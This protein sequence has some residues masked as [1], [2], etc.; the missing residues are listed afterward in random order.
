MVK[1]KKRFACGHQGYG[2]VCHRCQQKEADRIRRK[3]QRQAWEESFRY[4]PIDLRSFPKN[5]VKKTRKIIFQLNKDSNYRRFK[6]KRLRHNRF[7][8]SIPINRNYRLICRDEGSNIVPEA[9]VSH[10]DY[11]VCKP[12]N[13]K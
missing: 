7:M 12:G 2:Q 6:G 5:V 13:V 8:I 9:V 1:R 11:N 10:Q 4:D 3:K